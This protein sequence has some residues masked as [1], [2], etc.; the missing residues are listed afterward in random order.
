MN[1]VNLANN[2]IR[3]GGQGESTRRLGRPRGRLQDL[4]VAFGLTAALGCPVNASAQTVKI[5]MIS[6]YSGPDA[7]FGERMNRGVNLYM[8]LHQAS[9]PPGVKVELITRDDGG[10]NADRARALAQEMIVRDKVQFL[11]GVVWTPNAMAMAPVVTEA[12]VPFMIMNAGASV[13]TT[14]SPYIARFSYTMWQV[15]QPLGEWAAKKYRRAYIAVSDFSAGYDSE[16]AFERGFVS[17]G[18]QIVGKVRMPLVNPDF[19]PF[20]QKVKDVKPDVLYF[21]VPSGRL[22]S[23]VLKAYADLGLPKEG[24]RLITSNDITTEEELTPEALGVVSSLHYTASGNRAANKAFVEAYKREYGEHFYP[25][26]VAEQ[27][28]DTMD[29]IYAAIREQKG[30][31]DPDRTMEI[32]RNYR[33]DQS[34]RGPISIDPATRDIVHNIYLREIRRVDGRVS[35][36][37]LETIGTAVKDAWKETHKSP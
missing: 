37:E 7:A 30:V 23:G 10:P 17:G 21:F 36:V 25:E 2:P 32:V 5:G 12:K 34:P 18:G 26:F 4:A 33:G 27:A 16:E 24:I 3:A 20:M 11:T 13:I 31:I 19:A 29:A 8:K 1:K 28:W 9:L 15:T 35:N 6:T 22:A 14:R